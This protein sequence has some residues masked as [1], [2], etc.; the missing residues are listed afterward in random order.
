MDNGN[1]TLK[2]HRQ[3]TKMPLD[4]SGAASERLLSYV[5]GTL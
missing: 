4:S 2:A 3:T 5:R 1:K